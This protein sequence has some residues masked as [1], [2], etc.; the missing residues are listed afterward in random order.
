MTYGEDLGCLEEM[1]GEHNEA[2]WAA[3]LPS[4]LAFLL[5][6]EPASPMPPSLLT[7]FAHAPRLGLSAGLDAT[8]LSVEALHGRTR[9][10]WPSRSVEL[11]SLVPEVATVD[12]EGIVTAVGLGRASIEAR[13]AGLTTQA[14]VEVVADL[15]VELELN[16]GVPSWT[17]PGDTIFV[18]GSIT[19]LG[20][21]DP[22]V[23]PMTPVGANRFSHTLHLEAGTV[24]EF[25]FTRGS[26]ENVEKGAD[27][28]EIANRVVVAERDETIEATV[29][30]WADDW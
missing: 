13:F 19:E 14:E 6:E 22:G 18:T 17:P 8:S 1:G 10:T 16:V 23:V 21:W 15:R 28:A 30:S 29:A 4:I 24:V 12:P 2:A 7:A 5:G 27:G 9:L 26:W 20:D 25:K 11:T 3:R